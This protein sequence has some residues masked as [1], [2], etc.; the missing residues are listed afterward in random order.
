MEELA[1]KLK[2]SIVKGFVMDDE[3][4]RNPP[5]NGSAVPDY[6]DEMLACIRILKERILEPLDWVC[7]ISKKR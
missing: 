4:L 6:F 5:V 3:R 7:P 2:E 1:I